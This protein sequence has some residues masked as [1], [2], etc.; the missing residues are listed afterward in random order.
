[1]SLPEMSGPFRCVKDPVLRFSN[2]GMAICSFTAVADQKKKNEQSG[3]WEDDKVIFVKITTFKQLAEHVAASVQKG[4][5]VIVSN[6]R[7]SVSEW[8]AEDGTKRSTV[9]VVANDLGVSLFWDTVTVDEKPRAG[10]QGQQS[11][12]QP[13]ANPWGGSQPAANPWGGA[14][15]AVPPF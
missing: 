2:S 5:N 15:Q 6:G 7:A 10:Q 14:S 8:E 9:E 11:G 12:S 13:Q 3:Q 1:M 4:T